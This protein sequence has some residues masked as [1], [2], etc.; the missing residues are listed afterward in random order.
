M[1]MRLAIVSPTY[2]PNPCGVGDY[3][4][5]LARE[6][7]ESQDVT[8][9]TT[10]KRVPRP[11]TGVSVREAFDYHDPKSVFELLPELERLR[12]DWVVV[13]YDP[14]S[15][16]AKHAFNP[17][18]P[19]SMAA[20]GRSLLWGNFSRVILR[21]SNTVTLHR[22]DERYADSDQIGYLAVVRADIAIL[23]CGDTPIVHLLQ[24]S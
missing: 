23:N 12:P 6:L 19:S 16:G 21:E 1:H 10:R 8:V 15:Y 9:L 14:Y 4:R 13:Q 3:T 20:S 5:H 17:Y 22:F 2:P 18:L 7:A 24:A 11:D